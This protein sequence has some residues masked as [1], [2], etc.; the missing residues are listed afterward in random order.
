[1]EEALSSLCETGSDVPLV[2]ILKQGDE[3]V[4]LRL[5]KMSVHDFLATS[6]L[7]RLVPTVE[8]GLCEVKQRRDREQLIRE[9]RASKQHLQAL[10]ASILQIQKAERPHI[11]LDCTMIGQALT[12]SRF[13]WRSYAVGPRPLPWRG[14]EKQGPRL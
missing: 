4:A 13:T 2:V 14:D 10:S 5:I 6:Y 3:V 9:L 12:A 11:A 7:N 1:V 8:C